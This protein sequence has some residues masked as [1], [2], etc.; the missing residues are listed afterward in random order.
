[1]PRVRFDELPDDGRLWVFP[2]SRPLEDHET[3][4]CSSVVEAFLHQC[5]AHGVSLRCAHQLREGRFLLVGVD[6]DA[7]APSG[8]SIDALVGQLRTLGEELDVTFIDHTSVWYREEDEVRTVSRTE[9]RS[10]AKVGSVSSDG[11]VFDTTLTRVGQARDGSL[12]RPARD[13]W[14]GRAFFKEEVS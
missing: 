1:M 11:S 12:E 6:V 5:A 8:C 9:F 13:T 4:R 3:D 10:L 14:H 7:E 2:L